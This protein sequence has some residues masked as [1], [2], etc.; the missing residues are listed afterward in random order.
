MIK[1]LNGDQVTSYQGHSVI[2]KPYIP[3]EVITD[4]NENM[5]AQIGTAI[6]ELHSIPPPDFLPDQ[7]SY[8]FETFPKLNNAGINPEFEDW[9]AQKDHKLYSADSLWPAA[10]LV[11]GDVFYDNVLFEGSEFKAIIDFEDAC[12]H[13]KVFD[14]GMA[15]VG[16][17][18]HDQQ[19]NLSKLSALISGYQR[20][21][22]LEQ[23]EQDTLQ[24]FISYSA[25]GISAW[26]FWLNNIDIP[27]P[28][29][30]NHYQHMVNIFKHISAIPDGKFQQ[31]VFQD[32]KLPKN[33]FP[34]DSLTI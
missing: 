7:H 21:R 29:R 20:A 33:S 17:C 2:L 15:A 10:G 6:G 1:L 12:S 11:H 22:V 3:G 14:L 34:F 30:A 18:A 26:R 13:F 4:L 28:E 16:L 19:I 23:D 25:I 32:Q 8:W 27:D 9:L 5:I 24:L 31:A